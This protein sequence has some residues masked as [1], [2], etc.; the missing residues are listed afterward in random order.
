MKNFEDYLIEIHANQYVGLD[1]DMPDA[2]DA[3]LCDMDRDDLIDYCDKY[4]EIVRVRTLNE[5]IKLIEGI[6]K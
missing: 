5:T 4:A 6:M 1:D 2:F 3:W